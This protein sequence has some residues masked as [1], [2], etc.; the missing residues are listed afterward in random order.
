MYN[1]LVFDKFF[2]TERQE[3]LT[4]VM[5]E[6]ALSLI[7]PNQIIN[8]EAKVD[9]NL[10]KYHLDLSLQIISDIYRITKPTSQDRRLYYLCL[11]S[12][13]AKYIKDDERN[14][15]IARYIISRDTRSAI[16]EFPYYITNKEYEEIVKLRDIYDY[17]KVSA[18]AIIHSYDPTTNERFSKPQ[19][20]GEDILESG[21][22]K[23][24]KYLENNLCI[25]DYQLNAPKEYI[26]K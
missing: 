7:T 10:C 26:L 23:A 24:L 21:L 6:I 8:A 20:F 1:E 3:V 5:R 22:D 16:V 9:N 12:E 14:F 18:K 25:K 17:Y 13:I 11:M 4:D 15:I 19:T 2:D